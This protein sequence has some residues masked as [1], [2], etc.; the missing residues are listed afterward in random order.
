MVLRLA[1]LIGQTLVSQTGITTDN[2]VSVSGGTKNIKAY[3]S[4]GY[5][6]NK[7]T[8]IGQKFTRYSGKASVDIQA[9]DWFNMGLN[10]NVSHSTQQFGQSNLVIG[11]FVGSPATSIYNYARGLFKWAVPYDSA[12]NRII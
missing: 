10:V 5:L 6:N 3:A 12:G 1:I 2:T 9:T 8:S 4:F 11:S 7:G